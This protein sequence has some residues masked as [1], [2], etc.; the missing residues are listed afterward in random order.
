MTL[1]TALI[2]WSVLLALV[3]CAQLGLAPATT[4]DQNLAYA[5]AGVTTALNTIATATAAGQLSSAK[6]TQANTMVL[7]VKSTLDLARADETSNATSAQ[8]DL[9]LATQALTAVQTFLTA[10]GVK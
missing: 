4:L 5:Y 1:R 8:N 10:S 2:K 6:A 9:T 3:G 7:A